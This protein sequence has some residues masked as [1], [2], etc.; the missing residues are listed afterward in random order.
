[1]DFTWKVALETNIEALVEDRENL[2]DEVERLNK[3]LT[4][5]DISIE[6]LD[7]TPKN[8][9][10]LFRLAQIVMRYVKCLIQRYRECF[11]GN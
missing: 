7:V 2:Y 10:H 3:F 1:M 9:L 11:R 8:M 5:A 4:S 6:D